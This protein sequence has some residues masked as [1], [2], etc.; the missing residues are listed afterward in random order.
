MVATVDMVVAY[1]YAETITTGL[2]CILSSSDMSLPNMEATADATS[3]MAR[4][5]KIYTSMCH[6]VQW[7]TMPRLASTYVTLHTTDKKYCFLKEAVADWATSSS[8][9]LPTKLHAMHNLANLWRK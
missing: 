7:C 2:Y 6:A 5:A 1:T 4:T 9:R 8:V 3:V